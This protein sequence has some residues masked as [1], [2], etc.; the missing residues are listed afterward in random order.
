MEGN[1]GNVHKGTLEIALEEVKQKVSYHRTQIQQNQLELARYEE[2]ASSLANVIALGT[3]P[4]NKLKDAVGL[5]KA[6][7][8]TTNVS[9]R[10]KGFWK[11]LVTDA[12]EV[13][14]TVTKEDG[15]SM[16]DLKE[17]L[18]ESAKD[19]T[20]G[21]IYQ[22]IRQCIEKGIISKDKNGNLKLSN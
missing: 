18:R 14:K 16:S 19:A 5:S 2:M 9:H 8:T 15:I 3:A 12:M 7:E 6:T 1:V 4:A 17:A 22:G 11:D 10:K 21:A 13:L 20:E